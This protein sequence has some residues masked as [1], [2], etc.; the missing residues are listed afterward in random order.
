MLIS[1][2]LTSKSSRP[3]SAIGNFPLLSRLKELGQVAGLMSSDAG[4]EI[5]AGSPSSTET[6]SSVTVTRSNAPSWSRSAVTTKFGSASTLN[7]TGGSKKT[8]PAD[9]P[10]VF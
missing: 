1:T 3:T 2:R 10:M 4:K 9:A 7:A 5:A 6:E 8:P